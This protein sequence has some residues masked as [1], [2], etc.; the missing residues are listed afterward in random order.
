MWSTGQSISKY[1]AGAI[2]SITCGIEDVYT[3]L[4]HSLV[5]RRGEG[6]SG[7]TKIASLCIHFFFVVGRWL[8]ILS[9][10][11]SHFSSVKN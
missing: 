8:V 6:V 9:K 3:T 4:W 10:G 2:K 1:S 11:I 7:Y 5:S